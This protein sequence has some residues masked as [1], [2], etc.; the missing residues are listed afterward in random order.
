M[1][2]AAV[3][4]VAVLVSIAGYVEQWLWMRQVDYVGIFWTLLSVQWVMFGLAFVFAFL[5]LWLNLPR[6]PAKSNAFRGRGEAWKPFLIHFFYPDPIGYADRKSRVIAQDPKADRHSD[7]RRRR[8]VRCNRIPYHEWD[9]YLRFRYGGSLG[10]S[11]PRFGCDIGFYVFDLPFFVLLQSSLTLLTILALA[12]VSPIYMSLGLQPESG[13]GRHSAGGNATSHLS[14]LLIILVAN[15]GWGFYLDHYELVYSTLGIVYGAGYAADH[16]TRVALWIMV[17][18][19][20][21][22]CALLVLNFFRPRFNSVVFRRRSVRGPVDRWTG[23]AS[24][25]VSEIRRSAER[26]GA[27]QALSQKI[28]RFHAESL[29]A[30]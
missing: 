1:I 28:H 8:L 7:Q 22:G 25:L 27:Q 19:S 13:S 11:D 15:F 9:T 29:P 20:A 18:A 30:G 16:V 6:A 21:A 17:G 2:V 10:P 26:T 23:L 24:R 4:L 12:I 5:Y 14:V 3:L